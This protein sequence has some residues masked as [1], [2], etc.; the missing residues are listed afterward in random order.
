M[1]NLRFYAG[2]GSRQTPDHIL[3]KFE[4]IGQKL[5]ESCQFVL[6]SGGAIGADDAFIT[7]AF[8]NNEHTVEVYLPWE[9]YNGYYDGMSKVIPQW[10]FEMAEQNHDYWDRCGP[11]ARKMHARNC[12]IVF[13]E[14]GD[15][16][17]DFI[18]CYTD[19][20][21][22][23]ALRLAIKN[24]I[25]IYNFGTKDYTNEILGYIL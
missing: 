22:G 5:S 25:K 24:G 21:T 23:M 17:V 8:H 4:D 15:S 2:I 11:G 9:G 18:V 16:P 10:A 6:R 1:S 7:G 13:G 14:H 20:G 12:Q 3:D 19:G